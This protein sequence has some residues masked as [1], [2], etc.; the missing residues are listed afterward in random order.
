M[1]A[2]NLWEQNALRKLTTPALVDKQIQRCELG[3]R[4]APSEHKQ[5]EWQRKLAWLH[6]LLKELLRK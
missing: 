4:A 1:K 5:N 2:R 6:G 3:R